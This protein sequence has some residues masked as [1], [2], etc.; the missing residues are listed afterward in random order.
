MTL[1][2]QYQP[3]ANKVLNLSYRE[4]R[5]PSGVIRRNTIDIDQTNVSFQW[6][7]INPHWSV[8]GNWNYAI[9]DNKSLDLFGGIEYNSCCWG[10]R[11]VARRYL[12]D[13]DGDFQTGVFL[14]LELKGLA[15][16]GKKTV[17]FLK[18]KI[19]G[20]RSEF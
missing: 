16:I 20:Y 7:I 18:Q 9:S 17:D 13:I 5:A 10:M 14:Q 1:H 2:A 8:V 4:R 11:A 15:G 3:A 19:P 6:P 12:T